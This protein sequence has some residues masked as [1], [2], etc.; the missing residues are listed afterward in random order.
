MVKYIS[1][2]SRKRVV[3]LLIG[4]D[5]NFVDFATFRTAL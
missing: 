3:K 1:D 2:L 5:N 4:P